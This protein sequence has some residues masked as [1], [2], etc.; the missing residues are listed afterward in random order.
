MPQ[1]QTNFDLYSLSLFE[2]KYRQVLGN[3]TLFLQDFN[4]RKPYSHMDEKCPGLPPKYDRPA[5]C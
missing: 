5:G 3:Y 1:E 4:Q 2:D